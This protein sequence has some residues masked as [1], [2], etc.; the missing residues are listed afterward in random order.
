MHKF[1]VCVGMCRSDAYG[2]GMMYQLYKLLC[3]HNSVLKIELSGQVG[4]LLAS[5]EH[6][7]VWLIL[8][9][10]EKWHQWAMVPHVYPH[11]KLL[12]V[13]IPCM[14]RCLG[15]HWVTNNLLTTLFVYYRPKVTLLLLLVNKKTD[16][17][18]AYGYWWP[19][20]GGSG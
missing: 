16:Y 14:N 17:C 18:K 19:V 1:N 11:A 4:L 5:C 13:Y 2:F 15:R 7:W 10:D 3:F 8:F 6:Y 12:I 20:L 9:S